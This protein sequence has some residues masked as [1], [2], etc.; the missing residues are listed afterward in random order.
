LREEK[1]RKAYRHDKPAAQVAAAGRTA[2]EATTPFKLRGLKG[3]R[4]AVKA[5]ADTDIFPRIR[6]RA[7]PEILALFA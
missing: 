1:I 5:C 2:E 7:F 6:L 4:Q 3:R